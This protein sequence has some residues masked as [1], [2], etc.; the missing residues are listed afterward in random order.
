M[1]K[2]FSEI[3][4]ICLVEYLTVES[5][6]MMILVQYTNYTIEFKDCLD[7]IFYDKSRFEVEQVIF[8]FLRLRI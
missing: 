8:I 6:L 7:Y 3:R 5:N 1:C 2:L 4:N